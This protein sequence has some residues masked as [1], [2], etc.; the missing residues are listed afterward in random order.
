M[1]SWSFV[2]KVDYP[3]CASGE[4]LLR[5]GSAVMNAV[6]SKVL[7]GCLVSASPGRVDPLRR[8]PHARL[9]G[10]ASFYIKVTDART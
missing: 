10:L 8:L 4:D 7:A 6:L 9:E 5:G 1:V 3:E 2:S